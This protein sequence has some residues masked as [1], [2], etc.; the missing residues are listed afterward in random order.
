MYEKTATFPLILNNFIDFSNAITRIVK[1]LTRQ[2][3]QPLQDFNSPIKLRFG[4]A[5]ILT[6]SIYMQTTFR[7]RQNIGTSVFY[8]SVLRCFPTITSL[9]T[10]RMIWL[11]TF[12]NRYTTRYTLYL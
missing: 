8:I 9:S 2:G 10:F 7:Y 3:F 6:V 4:F 11:Q 1:I 5:H 12:P